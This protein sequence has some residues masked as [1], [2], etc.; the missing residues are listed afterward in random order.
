[1]LIFLDEVVTLLPSIE[2]INP[3]E[4]VKK[5]WFF[6]YLLKIA[7]NHTD[8]YLQPEVDEILLSSEDSSKSHWYPQ[9]EV[10]EMLLSTGD[11]TDTDQDEVVGK[12]LSTILQKVT[13]N[14]TDIVRW[15]FLILSSTGDSP[16]TMRTV[17]HINIFVA[18]SCWLL[19]SDKQVDVCLQL[20][21][22][23]N[24]YIAIYRREQ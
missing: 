3:A 12:L 9:D 23:Y 22:W 13:V 17:N 2:Y 1:M 4:I 20:I 7:D 11:H 24:I 14:H 21:T 8:N 6:N 19:S 5:K 18:W 15:K 16:I 10:G